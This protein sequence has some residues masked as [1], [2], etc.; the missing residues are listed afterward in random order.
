MIEA[1]CWGLIF[2]HVAYGLMFFAIGCRR[3]PVPSIWIS[4]VAVV[5]WPL[6]VQHLMDRAA[7]PPAGRGTP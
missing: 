7:P 5:C 3:R 1:F 2:M 4:A 6:M